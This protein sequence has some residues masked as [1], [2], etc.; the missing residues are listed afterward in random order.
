[1]LRDQDSLKAERARQ[2]IRAGTIAL[3][4]VNN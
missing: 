2:K 4:N 1:M 3:G